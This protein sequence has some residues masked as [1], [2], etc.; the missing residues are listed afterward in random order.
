VLA[1]EAVAAKAALSL[2][3]VG[4]GFGN[5]RKAAGS[6]AVGAQSC[7]V[8][9]PGAFLTKDDRSYSGPMFKKKDAS[10]FAYSDVYAFRTE[11]LAKKYVALRA[12]P[13]YKQ[14][15]QRQDDAATRASRPGSYVKLTAVK[16]TD[17]SDT[18]PTMYRELTVVTTGGKQVDGG[19]YDRYTL[20][21]GRVVVIV[22]VDASYG[23]NAAESQALANQTGDILNALDTA[24]SARLA[25][26]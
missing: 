5:Y 3:D 15:K 22:N 26:V 18:I 19:F 6:G 16:W 14:C 4:S 20:R 12:T 10:Y 9:A 8:T 1:D 13:A 7:S 25:G 17:P 23:R 21:H 11:A 24:L 2:A